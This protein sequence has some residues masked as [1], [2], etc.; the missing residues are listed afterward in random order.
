MWGRRGNLTI[1]ESGNRRREHKQL[2]QG[3][4]C[5]YASTVNI[6]IEF[7]F[8]FLFIFKINTYFCIQFLYLYLYYIYICI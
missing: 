3:F 6:F 7:M 4:L 5:T 2:N 8:V 1:V